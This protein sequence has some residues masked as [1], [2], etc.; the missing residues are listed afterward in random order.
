MVAGAQAGWITFQNEN[1]QKEGLPCIG[2]I[3]GNDNY[4]VS[5]FDCGATDWN[6]TFCG[7]HCFP[8]SATSCV[9]KVPE[10]VNNNTGNGLWYAP[11]SVQ[12]AC[13]FLG[14]IYSPGHEYPMAGENVTSCGYVDWPEER[15]WGPTRALLPYDVK[16][17]GC[18]EVDAEPDAKYRRKNGIHYFDGAAP[19]DP[20]FCEA[21]VAET[22]DGGHDELCEYYPGNSPR[23]VCKNTTMPDTRK[24]VA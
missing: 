6:S 4:L 10:G 20:A 19:M 17:N 12:T 5:Q 24:V 16:T 7:I 2:S 18:W 3:Y 15:T 13:Q 22:C 23:I 8:F 1:K 14:V 21:G 9:G 11:H